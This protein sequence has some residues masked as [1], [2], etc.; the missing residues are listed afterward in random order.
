ML[1]TGDRGY[2]IRVDDWRFTAWLPMD[3]TTAKVNWP[4]FEDMGE[5]IELCDSAP[6]HLS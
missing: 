3:Q 4:D 6:K 2:S 1:A 5:R